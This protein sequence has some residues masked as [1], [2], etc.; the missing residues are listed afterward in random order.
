MDKLYSLHVNMRLTLQDTI[1]DSKL[2]NL[3][4]EIKFKFPSYIVYDTRKR[5]H[6]SI[7]NIQ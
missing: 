3:S 6:S 1:I 4:Y 2:I 5:Y 7:S